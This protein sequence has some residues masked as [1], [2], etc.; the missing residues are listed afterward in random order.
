[1]N[2]K[3]IELCKLLKQKGVESRSGKSIWEDKL[4]KFYVNYMSELLPDNHEYFNHEAYG[5]KEILPAFNIIDT[6]REA[7]KI[8]GDD[9]RHEPSRGPINYCTR[10]KINLAQSTGAGCI[11]EWEYQQHLFIKQLNQ[12]NWL[13]LHENEK[14]INFIISSMEK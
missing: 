8:W 2:T 3:Y 12:F 11:E 6:L 13:P 5:A 9:N 7:K 10:C 4:G 14:A 1:M